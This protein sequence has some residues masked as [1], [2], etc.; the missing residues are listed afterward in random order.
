MCVSYRRVPARRHTACRCTACPTALHGTTRETVWS[1]APPRTRPHSRG[2]AVGPSGHVEPMHKP[3]FA[4]AV[5]SRHTQDRWARY[6]IGR[7]GVPFWHFAWPCLCSA[8]SMRRV[9]SGRRLIYDAMESCGVGNLS[10]ASW[11]VVIMWCTLFCCCCPLDTHSLAVRR[12]AV[13]LVGLG[14]M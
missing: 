2:I 3:G 11:H 5:M 10:C 1:A 14:W 12:S 7:T 6:A 13:A 8:D 4:I 9:S